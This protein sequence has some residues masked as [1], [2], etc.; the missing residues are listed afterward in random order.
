M[1]NNVVIVHGSFGNPY[2]NWIPWVYQELSRRSIP[3]IAPSFPTP[4]RQDYSSWASVLDLYRRFGLVDRNSILI[5]HSAG[6]AFLAK[7]L[8]DHDI[9]IRALIT[10]SGYN[11]YF[12]GDQMMDDLN[13]TFYFPPESSRPNGAG[14]RISYLS[15]NDPYIPLPVLQSFAGE[16]Q[17]EV[18]MI[19]NGGHFNSSSGF[20]EFPDL[21]RSV[22]TLIGA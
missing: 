6:A 8:R 12:S 7:Y 21:V 2:E 3:C 13:R 9:H 22:E 15:S 18:K 1:S 20:N 17:A 10:I 14:T 5:G 11:N 19:E 4:Q 16:I